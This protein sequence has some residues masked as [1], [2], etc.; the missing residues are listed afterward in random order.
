MTEQS[1]N[2][3]Y[4][5]VIPVFN[6]EKTIPELYRRL[7]AVMKGTK[8][9]YEIIFIDDGSKDMS[10]GLIQSLR[11]KDEHIKCISLSRNFGHQVAISAGISYSNGSATI[12]MDGDLQDPP[13]VIPSLIK[14]W[15]EGFEVVY[16]VRKKRKENILKRVLYR[17]FYLI[18]S[19][20]SYIAI[21]L[22]SGDF[23][24]LDKKVV[25][26]F[27]TMPEK[28]RF[29]RG[30]RAWVGFNQTGITY[31]RDSRFAGKPK[32]SLG[33]LIGLALDGIVSFS[34]RPLKF[35]TQA[36]FFISSLS[37]LGGIFYF[38]Y[39][40]IRGDAPKGFTTLA[41]L[42]L[43]LAGIQLIVIGIMGEYMGRIHEEVKNRPLFIVKEL[44]G[45]EDKTGE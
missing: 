23:S 24:V 27:N 6:E 41:I 25:E 9:N 42:I 30:I 16:A 11:T 28:N 32:Y 39:W 21:P 44:I 43:L 17:L 3:K 8:E 22:D 4:T 2:I 20:L 40:L 5:I 36:G 34:Y 18:L 38:L 33:K 19:R 13:E 12:L 7:T 35:A 14:K 15:E 31:E 1:E 37:F 10:L 26:L 29:I 45:L